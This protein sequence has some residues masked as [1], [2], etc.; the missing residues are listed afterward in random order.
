MRSPV[1]RWILAA[2]IAVGAGAQTFVVDAAGGPGSDFTSL[3][4]A[5]AT[6]P[7]GAVLDVRPGSYASFSLSG[8]AL[9]VLGGAGVQVDEGSLIQSLQPGQAVTL[10]GL[11]FR[12][13]STGVT[14]GLQLSGCDGPVT[15]VDCDWDLMPVV[16]FSVQPGLSATSAR[17]LIVKGGTCLWALLSSSSAV[18][19][20]VDL[21]GYDAV[22][23]G[24]V[25]R[26]ATP[27]LTMR[28]GTRVQLRGGTVTGGAE[29][30]GG[31]FVTAAAP[32]VTM[33]NP[34]LVQSLRLMG[35]ATIAAGTASLGPSPPAI[36]ADGAVRIDPQ[37]VLQTAASQPIQGGTV[38][39]VPMPEVASADAA[40]GGVLAATCGGPAGT[41][42][43]LLFGLPGPAF[44]LPGLQGELWA[45][46][47]T[48]IEM[49]ALGPAPI[50]AA[51]T[52]PNA[53]IFRGLRVA[54][55][56]ITFDP[57][58]GVETSNPSVALVR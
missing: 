39:S 24:G 8:K 30:V 17:Q 10:H 6:V 38:T 15:L 7:S 26:F 14:W 46:L 43:I 48:P 57:V 25:M 54:W 16:A 9:T 28:N 56:A 52:V 5:V 31:V 3:A 13:S 21:H 50:G 4:I 35:P 1:I 19:E 36:E 33:T 53:A 12:T 37:V 22:D 20:D 49:L 18:F 45:S 51:L 58:H 41:P 23:Q 29:A 47:A 11:R 42:A 34:G 27:G 55:H 44:E 2:A 32:G 40:P